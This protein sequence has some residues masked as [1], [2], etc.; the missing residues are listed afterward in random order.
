[1][2]RKTIVWT[3]EDG[4]EADHLAYRD[5]KWGIDGPSADAARAEDLADLCDQ[6]AEGANVHDFCGVHRLLAALLHEHVGREK[7]T[8]ILRDIAERGGLHAMNGVACEGDAFA[9]LGVPRCW[10]AWELR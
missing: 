4:D 9:N 7:A 1:M 10:E 3:R 8:A 2:G 5:P 6:E